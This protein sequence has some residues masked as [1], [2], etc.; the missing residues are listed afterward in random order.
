MDPPQHESSH[1]GSLAGTK[2][3][4]TGAVHGASE[5][6]VHAVIS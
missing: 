3:T 5:A 6:E 4:R 1:H 2:I